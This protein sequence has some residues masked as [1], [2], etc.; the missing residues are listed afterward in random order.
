MGLPAILV[1]GALSQLVKIRGK[2]GYVIP[3]H[4]GSL[5]LE[6]GKMQSM[7]RWLWEILQAL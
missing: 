7:G 5:I 6:A 2:K 1:S 4:S 3:R